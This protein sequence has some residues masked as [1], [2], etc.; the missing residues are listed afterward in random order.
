MISSCMKESICKV[1]KLCQH[2][3][4]YQQMSLTK[5][6]FCKSFNWGRLQSLVKFAVSQLSI[7]K[8]AQ[9]TAGFHG[10]KDDNFQLKF[11]DFF[12]FLL[13]T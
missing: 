11:V 12:I 3:N 5:T 8:T 6:K 9:Y 4:I 1:S 13:K 10:C 2:R 7:T